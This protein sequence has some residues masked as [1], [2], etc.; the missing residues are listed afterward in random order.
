M[1]KKYRPPFVIKNQFDSFVVDGV[2]KII[3]AYKK[4][5]KQVK[6][7]FKKYLIKGARLDTD[8]TIID[9]WEVD[10]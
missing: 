2:D 5:E 10:I 9:V 6:I 7:G 8:R 4:E 1:C 3:A